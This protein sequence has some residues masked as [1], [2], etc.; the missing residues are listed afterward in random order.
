M[1]RARGY[2]ASL[3]YECSGDEEVVIVP[4][5]MIDEGFEIELE[6]CEKEY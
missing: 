4:T 6:E 5:T 2:R 1:L 3:W